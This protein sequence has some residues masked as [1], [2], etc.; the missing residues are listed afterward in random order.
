MQVL[1]ET[2]SL[3]LKR[4][5]SANLRNMLNDPE[6]NLD[7]GQRYVQYLSTLD[8]IDTDLIHVLASYN[9]GPGNVLRWASSIRDG[10]DPLLY[11]E[12]LPLDETRAYVPR[13]LTYTWI[14]ATR[15]RLPMSS[16]DELAA[17]AW[18]RYYPHGRMQEADAHLH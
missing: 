15:M 5:S 8:G 4:P 6:T 12:A 1:P 9:A 3:V 16:L 14:Y 11:I 18:P 2:A 13:V 17:G 7:I 10:G